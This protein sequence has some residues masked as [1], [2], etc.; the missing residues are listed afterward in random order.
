[1]HHQNGLLV[2]LGSRVA[3]ASL[4][5][6]AVAVFTRLGDVETYG[7]Y[8]LVLAWSF[9]L[10]GTMTFWID[11]AFFARYQEQGRRQ[12]MS[13][14]LAMKAVALVL[15]ATPMA[16]LVWQGAL[17]ASFALSLFLMTAGLAA[18]EFAVTVPRTR[19]NPK[20]SATATLLR[21]A[22]TVTLGSAVL[23]AFAGSAV[24]LPI[25]VASAY[26]VSAVPMFIVY[27]ADLLRGFS[28]DVVRELLRYGWPLMLAG[29][30]WALAQNIDRLA[31]GHF[32]GSAS[33]GPYGAMADFL[34]QGFF[35][36]GEV[37]ALSL[38]TVAKRAASE[39]RH[40]DAQRALSEA[41][42]SI[43]VITVF[44]SVL[45]LALKDTIVAIFFGPQFHAAAIELLPLL[46]VASSILV[47]RTYY[48]GQIVYF[49]PSGML[50]FYASAL[51]LVV[52][53][54]LVFLLV[55]EHREHG[56]AIALIAGQCASC[57]VVA[58]WRS[59]SYRLPLPMGDMLRIATVGLGVWVIHMVFAR[60]IDN[61]IARIAADMTLVATSAGVVLW[62]YDLF[63][64]R[65][66]A[67]KVFA[68]AR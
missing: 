22:L 17:S 61:E 66:V 11:E 12:Y 30:T 19:M 53:V 34:K 10:H 13:S 5:L 7:T 62:Y 4:N 40:G 23:I 2:F 25:A 33:I 36:F 29:G 31:L 38:I 21:A 32:H 65:F 56:A 15:V 6:L 64:V 9:I 41:M 60:T 3:S 52:T 46:L 49:L 68:F 27:R 57:A 45:V 37:V 26:L 20:M 48:F 54:G 43:A 44:G 18:H 51:Q 1:M 59:A 67:R 50:Q 28:R 63:A 35:V 55:P 47:F 14:A 16:L 24:A 39:G 42:R 8:L 58:L